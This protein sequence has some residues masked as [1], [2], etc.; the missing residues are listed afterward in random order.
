[1]WNVKL[2]VGFKRLM[3]SKSDKTWHIFRR[4]FHC[5][6][7]VTVSVCIRKFIIKSFLRFDNESKTTIQEG[8]ILLKR[9]GVDIERGVHTFIGTVI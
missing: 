5:L 1:L 7:R 9:C 2:P 3:T 4:K 6:R 8:V